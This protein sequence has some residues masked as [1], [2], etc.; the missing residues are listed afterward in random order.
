[1]NIIPNDCYY[2]GDS[3]MN[4][5]IGSKRSGWNSVWVNRRKHDVP[6]NSNYFPDYI[7]EGNKC[8]IDVMKE[9]LVK[10]HISY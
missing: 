10:H 1:M 7:I 8:P 5:V 2:F 3:F 9:I 4:D 6:S